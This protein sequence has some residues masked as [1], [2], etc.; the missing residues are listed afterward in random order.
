MNKGTDQCISKAT[1]TIKEYHKQNEKKR[2]NLK[3]RDVK[4]K[5]GQNKKVKF[6][7]RKE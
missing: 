1:Y 7:N 2:K 5:I 4:K 3:W 6:N